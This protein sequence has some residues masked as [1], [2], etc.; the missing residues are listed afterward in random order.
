M[1]VSLILQLQG[2]ILEKVIFILG[3]YGLLRIGEIDKINFSDLKILQNEIKV[4]IINSKTSANSFTFL[5]T[6]E[7]AINILKEY[8]NMVPFDNRTGKFLK[9]I[10]NGK[11]IKSNYGK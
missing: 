7:P 10:R 6:Y 5:I 11:V 4:N 3:F 1:H 9:A 2:Y 8:L